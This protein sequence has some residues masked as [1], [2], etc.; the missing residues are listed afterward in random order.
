MFYSKQMCQ[1]FWFSFL[2]HSF[3]KSLLRNLDISAAGV[4]AIQRWV[5]KTDGDAGT[6]EAHILM[7]GRSVNK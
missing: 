5:R 7:E 3:N 1:L 6:C 2:C 4:L